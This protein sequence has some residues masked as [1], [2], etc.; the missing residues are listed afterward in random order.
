MNMDDWIEAQTQR[1]LQ[2]SEANGEFGCLFCELGVHMTGDLCLS[3]ACCDTGAIP[4]CHWKG[5]SIACE[6]CKQSDDME[7]SFSFYSKEK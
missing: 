4:A 2:N 5:R 6:A 7:L 1:L 3:T